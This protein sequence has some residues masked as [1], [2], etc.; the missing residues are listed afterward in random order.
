[1]HLR[2][3]CL[4]ARQQAAEGLESDLARAEGQ[5]IVGLVIVLGLGPFWPESTCCRFSYIFGHGSQSQSPGNSGRRGVV[6]IVVM[7]DVR[8]CYRELISLRMADVTDG[9]LGGIWGYLLYCITDRGQGKQFTSIFTDIARC[10]GN[11][12]W[13]S[14]Y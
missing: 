12:L 7:E 9:S 4:V 14:S 8:C 2:H 1:M 6:A 5:H 3:G 10:N 11:W 13:D